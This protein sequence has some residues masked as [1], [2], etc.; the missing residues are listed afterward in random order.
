MSA[1]GP[2]RFRRRLLVA[3]AAPLVVAA[4]GVVG[5][6]EAVLAAGA[7]V[8]ALTAALLWR[9]TRP[10]ADLAAAVRRAAGDDTGAILSPTR[11]DELGRI[12]CD[13][14]GLRDRLVDALRT[15]E[16]TQATTISRFGTALDT[17]AA[18][19]GK[20]ADAHPTG[21]LVLDLPVGVNGDRAVAACHEL[22]AKS[23]AIRQRLLT[24]IRVLQSCPVPLVATDDRGL[25][26]YANPAGERTL[27]RPLG[28]LQ[29]VT[30]GALLRPPA[31]P[32]AV[33]LPALP[34]AGVPGWLAAG[35]S[36]VVADTIGRGTRLALVAARSA[37][38]AGGADA[39]WCVAARD[40]TDDLQRLAADRAGAREEALAAMLALADRAAGTA[41]EVI[42]AHARQLIG[43][44]KQSAQRDALLPRLKKVREMAADLDAQVR[45][46]RWLAAALWADFPAPTRVEFLAAES[47]RSAVE[48]LAVRLQA[49]DSSVLVTDNG[50]WLYCDEDW[51]RTAVHGVLTHAVAAA[52]GG[53]IGV[54][55]RLLACA[56]GQ[57]EGSLE[58]EVVD[59][60]PELTPAQHEAL[61]RPFGG[62]APVAFLPVADGDGCLPGLFL[63]GRL[64]AALGGEMRFD[65]TPSGRL[66]VRLIVPTR[67]PEAAEVRPSERVEKPREPE[68]VEE[69]CLGWRLGKPGG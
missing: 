48:H 31:E 66:I 17:L 51:F 65:A 14:E 32:D 12:A 21:P 57:P 42:Q 59:A 64:V 6:P 55:L 19:V 9:L 13:V 67:L 5:P 4:V 22:A 16:A 29:R 60:G 24:A 15:A 62:L 38:P 37:G 28:Q 36:A 1:G 61:A 69:L 3:A 35:G 56:P 44:A 47:I 50:G 39:L 53:P 41:G 68:A 26:R 33:G 52:R 20:I 10:L 8:A 25:I 58:V 40:L 23:A 30:L 45:L 46:G 34:E 54:K 27:G 11:G 7:A 2:S 49:A 43:E 18:A 63:A